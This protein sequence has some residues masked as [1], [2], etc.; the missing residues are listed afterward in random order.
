MTYYAE[1]SGFHG[2]DAVE[3]IE[4]PRQDAIGRWIIENRKDIVA[5]ERAVNEYCGFSDCCCG[6]CV[7]LDPHFSDLSGEY[8]VA[9][10]DYIMA[11]SVF[12]Y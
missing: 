7:G 1:I 5:C 10:I 11:V 12:E 8:D 4:K 9:K 3:L 2:K 6:G